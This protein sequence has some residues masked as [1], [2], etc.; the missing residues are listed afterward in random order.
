MAYIFG[1]SFDLYSTPADMTAGYWDS[2]ALTNFT[3]PAGRFTGSQCLNFN[4]ASQNIVKSSAVNDAVHHIVC[5]FRQTAPLTGTTLGVFF[6]FTDNV[7]NQCCIV[8][9]SDGTILLTSATPGGTTLATYSSAVTATNTWFAFE[10][11][12]IISNTV[13]RFRARKN[14]NTVDD[15]DSGATLNTRPGTNSYANKL[16]MQMSSV[17]NAQQIDDLLWRSDASSVAWAGDIRCY[18]RMP[19]STVGTPQFAVSPSTSVNSIT[20]TTTSSDPTG[21]S[22]Y[23]TFTPAYS[24]TI[25]SGTVG[26]NTGFTGNLKATIFADASGVPGGVLGSATTITNPA[27]GVNALV[28]G[29]PVAV[30]K[31]TPYWIGFSHDV[32]TVLSV[33]AG[34]AGRSSTTVA[35]ASFPTASPTT[36]GGAGPVSYSV[37]V[38]ATNNNAEFVSEPQQDGTTSYVYDSTVNDVDFYAIASLSPAPASVVAVTTRGFIEKSDAGTRT[39][40]IQIKSGSTTVATPTISLSTSFGWAWRTDTTDPNTG[41]AWTASAVNAAQ[42]GPKMVS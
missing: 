12:I 26:I 19:A 18:T 20:A 31:G 33:G 16:T 22:K 35:Y 24:G 9:R 25:G 34:T 17:V 7:T 13:G 3:L 42:I 5:A 40:S 38:T 8:F 41:S 1:D 28:F 14:G 10:F 23:V 6:Q 32:T 4:T 37:T 21:T 15:F 2:G 39:G 27:T 30:T 36:L 29:T 11:E